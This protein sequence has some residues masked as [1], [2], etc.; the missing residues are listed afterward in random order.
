MIIKVAPQNNDTLTTDQ[1]DPVAT[2]AS[3]LT[4]TGE[5]L[6]RTRFP[7]EL[8]AQGHQARR[9]SW[10]P[11]YCIL[12]TSV[13]GRSGKKLRLMSAG[14]RSGQV[15]WQPYNMADELMADDWEVVSPGIDG[16]TV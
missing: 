13:G 5:A 6:L 16:Q 7:T 12:V 4:P 8:L 15:E 3:P 9:L 10:A 1:T 14:G 11:G 2:A